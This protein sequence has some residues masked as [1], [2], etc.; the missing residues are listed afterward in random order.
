MEI[1]VKIGILG[2]MLEEVSSIKEMMIINKESTI[3]NRNYFEGTINDTEVVLVFSRWGKVASASTTTTLINKFAVD[4][5]LFTGV[6]GAVDDCLNIGDIVIGN[7]LYQHDMDARPF[8]DKFQIP[9]TT[10]IIFE[11]KAVDIEKLESAANLFVDKIETVFNEDLLARF[12][13]FK[14][15]VHVGLIASGDQFISAPNIHENLSL[16]HKNNK[17]LA[18]EME[19]SSVAQVCEE[20]SVPYVIIR[21][22]SDKADHSAAIDFQAFISEIASKYSSGIVR[23]YLSLQM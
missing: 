14:P 5:V 2:A 13:I 7:G 18:V 17:T 6:A 19:G 1:K 22:I 3:G 10:K 9:L 11:P 15:S 20:H 23:E 8:F 4:F 16:I 21:V 12:S